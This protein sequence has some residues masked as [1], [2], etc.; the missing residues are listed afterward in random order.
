MNY[1]LPIHDG[2]RVRA[3]LKSKPSQAVVGTIIGRTAHKYLVGARLG[4][5]YVDP[6]TWGIE[7]VR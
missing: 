7:E 1:L 6:L 3:W 2:A 4:V 5:Y